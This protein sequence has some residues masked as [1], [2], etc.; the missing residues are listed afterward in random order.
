MLSAH[1]VISPLG[2]EPKF[3]LLRYSVAFYSVDCRETSIYLIALFDLGSIEQ[4]GDRVTLVLLLTN[5]QIRLGKRCFHSREAACAD[6]VPRSV[7][8][9]T[10]GKHA[11]RRG[12][13]KG[14]LGKWTDNT[15]SSRNYVK[16]PGSR[17]LISP[18][19]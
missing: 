14:P 6:G 19:I 12:V 1:R 8:I 10:M 11:R 18:V 16:V 4:Q 9:G 5:L 13:H 2:V 3:T 7:P 15:I 17:V